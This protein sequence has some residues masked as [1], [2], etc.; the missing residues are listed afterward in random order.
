MASATLIAAQKDATI[1]A[2]IKLVLTHGATTYTY[3]RDRI[4]SCDHEE[5]PYTQTAAIVLDNS[6]GQ[7]TGLDL[8]GY[9]GVISYGAVTSLGDE[10]QATAPLWVIGQ[11]LDS[12]PGELACTLQ[13]HGIPDRL[14][15]DK[16]SAVY[17]PLDTDTKTVKTLI[18]EILGATIACYNHCQAYSIEWDSEDSLIDAYQP[19]DTFRIY[20]NSSRMAVLRRLLDYTKCVMRAE[21]DGKV[22]IFQPVISG[23]AYDY[24]YSLAEGEHAF[25]SK[26]HRNR[27][28]MPNYIHVQT[29]SY[30]AVQYSG[31]AQDAGSVAAIGEIRYYVRTYLTSN[32]QGTGIAEAV[33]SKYQLQASTGKATVPLNALARVFDYVRVTD[34]RQEDERAGSIGYLARHYKA[35]RKGSTWE[36]DFAFGNWLSMQR[37]LNNLEL[38]SDLS[39]DFLRLS[40][41]NLNAEKI[42]AGDIDVETLSAICA[43]LGDVTVA[44]GDVTLGTAGIKLF[45]ENL[46]VYDGAV[47]AGSLYESGGYVR[48]AG[49]NGYGVRL[50]TE[51]GDAGDIVLN[52][53]GDLDLSAGTTINIKDDAETDD[54]DAETTLKDIG[55]N[56]KYDE[57]HANDLYGTTHCY[58]E[59]DDLALIKQLRPCDD[60]PSLIATPS[61]PE[62]LRPSREYAMAKQLRKLQEREQR[63]KARLFDRIQ[64]EKDPKVRSRLQLKLQSVG[65][66][67]QARLDAFADHFDAE[68]AQEASVS[69]AVFFAI[70]ALKQVAHQLDAINAR[71]AA[72]EESRP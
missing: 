8:K 4:L 40:V 30:A 68:L 11:E 13:L 47:K 23:V 50:L 61:L 35:G 21:D 60:N 38:A 22:H 48:L 12:S 36:M 66:D 64:A 7:L 62:F 56:T 37:L 45:G 55:K 63:Q 53:D 59:H 9:Q 3:T 42:T 54:L 27:L 15:L 28:V 39:Y 49:W 70:G 57:I 10:Y 44:G 18:G 14:S 6:D 51:A 34:A 20:L 41:K 2:L 67:R 52:A 1:D 43:Y 31:I 19:K 29:P 16:A 25:F 32:A 5:Q 17:A 24:E 26:A 46:Y 65:A 72:L 69:R 58:D 33:L 71:L